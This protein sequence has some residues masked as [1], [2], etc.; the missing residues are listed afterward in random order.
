M[1]RQ[2][3]STQLRM[4]HA[5]RTC[6]ITFQEMLFLVNNHIQPFRFDVIMQMA[7]FLQH[8]CRDRGLNHSLQAPFNFLKISLVTRHGFSFSKL[9]AQLHYVHCLYRLPVR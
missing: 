2:S 1:K 4:S 9:L 7:C 8:P 5:R 3:Y 6:P